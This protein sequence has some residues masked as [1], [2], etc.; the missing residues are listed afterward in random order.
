MS[1]NEI[2]EV[3][4]DALKK[5]SVIKDYGILDNEITHI[6]NKVTKNVLNL[7]EENSTRE[8]NFK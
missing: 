4:L 7:I 1:Q 6:G 2:E 5:S 3:I 8:E